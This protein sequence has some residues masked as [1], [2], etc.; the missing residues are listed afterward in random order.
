MNILIDADL[1]R[2]QLSEHHGIRPVR[3]TFEGLSGHGFFSDRHHAHPER[4][5]EPRH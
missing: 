1:L 4:R 3:P 2:R 5:P